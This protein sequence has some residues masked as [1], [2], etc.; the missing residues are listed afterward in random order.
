MAP[1]F[2]SKGQSPTTPA[3][4]STSLTVTFASA[5]TAGNLIVLCLGGDKNTGALTSIPSG[6]TAEVVLTSSSVSLYVVWGVSAGETTYNLAWTTT[7]GSGCY[8]CGIEY[9]EAG[10]GA[11]QML[12]KATNGS[13]GTTAVSSLTSGTTA[14][15]SQDGIALGVFSVDSPSSLG[16]TDTIAYTNSFISREKEASVFG[17]GQG[18]GWVFVGEKAITAGN[19]AETTFSYT[20]PVSG[21]VTDQWSGAMVTFARA[22]AAAA[23]PT[24]RIVR[25]NI[26]YG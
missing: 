7:A 6:F 2:V 22:A 11:W 19:T 10:A 24:L 16:S 23:A 12:A 3:A 15:L 17:T 25:S 18:A 21:S 14:A 9:S 20:V 13:D 1:S 26:R 4:G 5:T 8:A